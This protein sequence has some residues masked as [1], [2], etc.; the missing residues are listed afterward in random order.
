MNI[1]LQNLVVGASKCDLGDLVECF[2]VPLSSPFPPDQG[3]TRADLVGTPVQPAPIHTQAEKVTLPSESAPAHVQTHIASISLALAGVPGLPRIWFPENWKK[4]HS[5]AQ[6]ETYK[7][8]D[9]EMNLQRQCLPLPPLPTSHQPVRDTLT[10]WP[11][12][13]HHTP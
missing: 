3:H 12:R 9:Q 2:H 7:H 10:S 4:S 6:E 13:A 11:Q 5:F 8:T 1:G